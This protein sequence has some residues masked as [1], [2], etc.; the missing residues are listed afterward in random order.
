MD[1]LT[2]IVSIVVLAAVVGGIAFLA[3]WDIPAPSVPVEKVI[4]NE[5]FSR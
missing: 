2:R 4:S 5:R 3:V 1:K